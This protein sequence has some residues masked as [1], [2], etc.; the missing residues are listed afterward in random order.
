MIKWLPSGEAAR[1]AVLYGIFGLLTTVVNLMVYQGALWAGMAYGYAN[2]LAFVL[3]ILFA[4]VTNKRVVF[5]SHRLSLEGLVTEFVKFLSARLGTFLVEMLG[6]W[7]FIE[8]MGFDELIPKYVLTVLVIVLNY[9]LSK[10][11]VFAKEKE[12]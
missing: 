6:L 10:W 1:E 8:L 12:T 2:G 4:Y 9:F 11:V 5:Q 3:A 7:V